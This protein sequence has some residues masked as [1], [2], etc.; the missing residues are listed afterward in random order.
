[1]QHKIQQ[2]IELIKDQNPRVKDFEKMV[3]IIEQLVQKI[4]EQE[5]E[6]NK[7]KT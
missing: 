3:G 5:K 4:N 1:M 2:L 6:I 7:N